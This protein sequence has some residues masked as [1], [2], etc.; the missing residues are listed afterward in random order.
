MNKRTL[1][2]VQEALAA[3]E[4]QNSQSRSW[5]QQANAQAQ[6]VLASANQPRIV[7]GGGGGRSRGG[8][9]AGNRGIWG[10]AVSMLNSFSNPLKGL[11]S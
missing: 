3:V 11:F 7:G 10:T 1:A 2:I 5:A 4:K 9:S 6:T 8:G